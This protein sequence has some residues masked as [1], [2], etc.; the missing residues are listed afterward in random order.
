[1]RRIRRTR[2]QKRRR[3]E[4]RESLKQP[5][6]D[7][8][9]CFERTRLPCYQQDGRLKDQPANQ[10]RKQHKPN[11]EPTNEPKYGAPHSMSE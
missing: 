3:F 5:L 8:I 11:S 7:A 9:C 6:G 10:P 1:V 2:R 4:R